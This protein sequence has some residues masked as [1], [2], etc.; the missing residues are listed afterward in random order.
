MV[1]EAETNLTAVRGL[2]STL[3]IVPF[4]EKAFELAGKD[5]LQSRD[6]CY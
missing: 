2:P 1:G 5:T 6:D 4:S 3:R